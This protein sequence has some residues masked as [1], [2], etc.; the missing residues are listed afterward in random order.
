MPRAIDKEMLGGGKSSGLL[1]RLRMRCTANY[2]IDLYVKASQDV[3]S[4]LEINNFKVDA[5]PPYSMPDI[6]C[7]PPP[8]PKTNCVPPRLPCP[9]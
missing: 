8:P 7:R 1:A 4:Y 9:L 6:R 5:C 3:G 2:D